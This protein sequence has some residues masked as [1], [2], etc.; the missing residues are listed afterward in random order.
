[1]SLGPRGV[2][3]GSLGFRVHLI[4]DQPQCRAITYNN[5]LQRV[6]L[7]KGSPQE[8]LTVHSWVLGF[9]LVMINDVISNDASL[10]KI[11]D[12][13]TAS[14]VVVHKDLPSKALIIA[15]DMSHW[16][17]TN[18]MQLNSDKCKELR[19]SLSKGGKSLEVVNCC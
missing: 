1:M 17:K 18:R 12:D 13:T 14:E 5:K 2:W 3:W 16:S 15:N 8:C 9:F 19:I 7:A 4:T 11:V 6:E 10:W